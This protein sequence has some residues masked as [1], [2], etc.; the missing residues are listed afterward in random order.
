MASAG[1]AK[2][3][4]NLTLLPANTNKIV[5]IIKSKLKTDGGLKSQQIT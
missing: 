2:C 4:G 1:N 3:S 5:K